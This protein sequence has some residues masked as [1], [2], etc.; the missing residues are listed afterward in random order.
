VEGGPDRQALLLRLVL[1]QPTPASRP[2]VQ[3]IQ[4]SWGT[5]DGEFRVAEV[6][7]TDALFY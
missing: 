3:R 4:A 7:A 6:L 2:L 1:P 5:Q